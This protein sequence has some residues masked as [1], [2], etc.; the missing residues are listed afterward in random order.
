MT[1]YPAYFED[2]YKFTDSARITK[3]AKDEQGNFIVLNQTIFYPQGGGQPSD[4]GS[5]EIGEISIP[6]H[7]VKS[8][9][10]E[11][12]H[13]TDED[14]SH[15]IEQEGMCILDQGLRLLNARLHTAGHLI[16]NVIEASYPQW[17]AQKG[18]HFPEQC[19]VEFVDQS[20]AGENISLVWVHKEIEK[21]I[22]MDLVIQKDQMTGDKFQEWCPNLPY[23]VPKEQSLRVVR[24]GD[25]PFSPCGGTHVRSLKELNG[26]KITKHKIKKNIL[27][28]YYDINV[29]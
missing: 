9:E 17:V 22:A 15:L 14:Y 27:K 29:D 1:T 26:L 5:I 21:A 3:A 18:H 12:R 13:Y 11:I 28:I 24:I 19:Y 16:S 7:S 2:T 20:W 8:V 25:F 4:Q 10:Q 6:I 23:S